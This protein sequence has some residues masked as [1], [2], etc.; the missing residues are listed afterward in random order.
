MKRKNYVNQLYKR[1]AQQIG[2]VPFPLIMKRG[3]E[4][5]DKGDKDVLA[6]TVT[7]MPYTRFCKIAI[8]QTNEELVE[9]IRH[10]L[11][12]QFIFYKKGVMGEDGH[13]ESFKKLF[14]ELWGIDV[15]LG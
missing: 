8:H 2:I 13:G 7:R 14:R 9:T 15:Y 6:E 11:T 3:R 10:E 1:M 4:L 12:H 5:Y